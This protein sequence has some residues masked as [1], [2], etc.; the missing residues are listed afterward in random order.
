M[1]VLTVIEKNQLHET[2]TYVRFVLYF[3]IFQKLLFVL[4]LIKTKFICVS[5]IERFLFVQNTTAYVCGCVQCN[6]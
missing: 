6:I 5:V 2:E 1:I 3:F 4:K